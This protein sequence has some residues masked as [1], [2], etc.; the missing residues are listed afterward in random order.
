MAGLLGNI[1]GALGDNMAQYAHTRHQSE[2]AQSRQA[3]QQDFLKDLE[4]MRAKRA[5]QLATRK[6]EWQVADLKAVN[7]TTL[8][9]A[10]IRADQS[11]TEAEQTI[12]NRQVDFT[13]EDLNNINQEVKAL[14]RAIDEYDPT[15]DLQG[16]RQAL[17]TDSLAQ[18]RA[19]RARLMESIPAEVLQ[20]A[21]PLAH[22]L[23]RELEQLQ[24][25]LQ[26]QQADADAGGAAPDGTADNTTAR[27]EPYFNI[28]DGAKR[29]G[30]S[31]FW[32]Q[33]RSD[34]M[35]QAPGSNYL[36]NRGNF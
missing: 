35:P 5:E 14:R 23:H 20:Q 17:L 29:P 9:A 21:G 10:R 19:R 24:Q 7:Q 3:E 2:L 6:R 36:L 4:S 31:D 28:P 8:E 30:I 15:T 11:R 32:R 13:R 27:A 22:A 18:L 25:T 34:G 1:A 16:T 33:F 26:Q 12:F